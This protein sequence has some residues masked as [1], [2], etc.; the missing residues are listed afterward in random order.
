[1]T[2]LKEQQGL[3]TC[4]V[5]LQVRRR[6]DGFTLIEVVVVVALIALIA[7]VAL[8]SISSYFKVSIESSARGMATTFRDAYNSAILSGNV[9]RFAYDIKTGEYWVESGP[10]TTLLDT[11]A[12]RKKAEDRRRFGK[13]ADETEQSPFNMDKSVTK[14]KISLPR[15]VQFEDIVSQ[16]SKEPITAGVAYTHIFPQGLTEQSIVHLVDESKHHVSLVFTTI[17]GHTDVYERYVTTKEV[18]GQ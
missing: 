9:Y 16:Q 15:G 6:H 17:A 14:K 4:E 2:K 18:F 11:E 10:P 12:S 8:P 7:I 1:M 3:I 5:D 13:K